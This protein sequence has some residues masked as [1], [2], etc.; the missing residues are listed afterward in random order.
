MIY[1][2]IEF[3]RLSINDRLRT[4]PGP[5]PRAPRSMTN[6]RVASRAGYTIRNV[7]M[8][9]TGWIAFIAMLFM[10]LAFLGGSLETQEAL[11]PPLF[12]SAIV[13]AFAMIKALADKTVPSGQKNAAVV[14]LIFVGLVLLAVISQMQ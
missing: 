3:K 10:T 12:I 2:A 8:W 1:R 5:R 4:P 6:R 7:D 14:G 9:V 11:G 13:S